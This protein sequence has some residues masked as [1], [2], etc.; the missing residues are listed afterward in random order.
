MRMKPREHLRLTAGALKN[1]FIAQCED[2]L[3]V[4]ILWFAGLHWIRV[5][6]APLWAIL[7]AFL[8]FVPHL[9]PVLGML[10]PV[11]A[12]AISRHDWRHPFYVLLLY[13]GIVMVDGF[14][15]QPYLMKRSAKV[16]IWASILAPIAFGFIIPFWGVL[17]A[18]PLLAVIYAYR[19][20]ISRRSG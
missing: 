6:L 18:P 3:A 19:E 1:W 20:R 12:A 16:P 15:L 14:L 2:S 11:L 10:G 7:A 8:Q 5:P 4:G 17:L 13:A 9:G